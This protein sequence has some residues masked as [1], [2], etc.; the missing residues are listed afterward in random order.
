MKADNTFK[1]EKQKKTCKRRWIR[2]KQMYQVIRFTVAFGPFV[3]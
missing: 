3:V 1:K 2:G